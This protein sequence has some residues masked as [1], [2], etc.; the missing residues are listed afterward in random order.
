MSRLAPS[1]EI[2]SSSFFDELQENTLFR[3]V[4]RPF[5]CSLLL[6]R[7]SSF[8]ATEYSK[9]YS[10]V[11]FSLI[12]HVNLPHIMPLIPLDSRLV[13]KRE[14][15]TLHLVIDVAADYWLQLLIHIHQDL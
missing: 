7:Q 9:K 3:V 4:N 8:L 2:N 13:L 6:K 12:S 15:N 14:K 1:F 11:N 10:K 5:I